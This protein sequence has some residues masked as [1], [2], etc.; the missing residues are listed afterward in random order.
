GRDD[1]ATFIHDR[2]TGD[3]ARHVYVA[4]SDATRFGRSSLWASDFAAKNQIPV[5]ANFGGRL[6]QVTGQSADA[7][8]KT[9]DL[10]AFD[11][12]NGHVYPLRSMGGV[13]YPS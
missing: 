3:T 13:P 9:A 12:G 10:V 1:I 7:G 11:R 5:V 4:L 2:V 6:S 8:K